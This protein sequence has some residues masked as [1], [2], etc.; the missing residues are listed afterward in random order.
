MGLGLGK[1]VKARLRYFGDSV[2]RT[3]GERSSKK[4]AQGLRTK[5]KA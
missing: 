3:V 4:R 5:L 1:E 2:E